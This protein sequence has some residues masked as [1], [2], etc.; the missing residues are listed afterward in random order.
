LDRRKGLASGTRS[1]PRKIDDL[2]GPLAHPQFIDGRYARTSR[3]R[4]QIAQYQFSK[5]S[6]DEVLATLGFVGL[7]RACHFFMAGSPKRM[8]LAAI[9]IGVA[10]GRNVFSRSALALFIRIGI[11]GHELLS[12]PVLPGDNF[13]LDLAS[14]ISSVP[15][16]ITASSALESSSDQQRLVSILIARRIPNVYRNEPLPRCQRI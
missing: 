2:V 15:R 3:C 16:N 14:R 5:T 12:C 9:L 8:L 1:V 10:F 13:W 11:G 7:S 6:C 4:T